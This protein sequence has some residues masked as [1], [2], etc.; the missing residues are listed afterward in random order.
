MKSRLS[1][2][3]EARKLATTF[4]ESL[5]TRPVHATASVDQL[6]AA[7]KRPL[8]EEMRDPHEVLRELAANA[9][10]G[11]IG[12][13]GPRYFG[14]VIGGSHPIAVGADWLSSA[15][16]Q[17]AGIYSTSPMNSVIEEAVREWVLELLDLP[18][19]AGVGYVTGGQMA[20]T[21]SLAAARHEVLRRVGW[22][23]ELHGLQGAPRITVVVSAEAHITIYAAL[24]FLGLGSENVLKVDTDEQGRMI[25][26]KFN[27]TIE[28]CDGP[29]IVCTQAGNVNTGSF[30]P[31]DEI[32]AAAHRRNA[33]VHV[34]GAFGLWASASPHYRH[35]VKGFAAADSWATDA[36]KW[37]N[38]PYD[39]G[40][41]IVANA[42]AHRAALAVTAS[43]LEQS[44][45]AERDCID[46]VPEF[47]RRARAI[48]L[49]A[50]LQ[51]LGRDGVADLVERCCRHAS[52]F[53]QLLGEEKG[54]E[55]LND[56]VLNQTLVRFHAEGMDSDALTRATVKRVQDDG[57]CWLSGTTWK[58]VAAM[59]ISVSN[60]STTE[61]DVEMSAAAILSAYR[62]E[63]AKR[64]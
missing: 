39:C 47:S 7:L 4:I 62:A 42:S 46:W 37:I 29:I 49:Y 64:N 2:L 48:P 24:R 11:I 53:A 32:V 30:D 21:T 19:S 6:R 13:A 10:A 44:A 51:F 40:M 50:T 16:D 35:L 41:T 18:R 3:D 34:D 43:Y 60:W 9:D 55:I 63:A 57:V 12:S 59:R 45:G 1:L 54:V 8:P 38:V 52:R 33:W 20:N 14:Y 17:N 26:S 15:W 22:D 23:V 56:V 31:I 58:N 36:H 27:E 61:A 5:P 25:A 28:Q